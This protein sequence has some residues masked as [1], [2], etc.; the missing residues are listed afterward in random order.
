MLA[1]LA[2]GDDVAQEAVDDVFLEDAK[3]A[4]GEHVHLEGFEF[5]AEFVGDVAYDDVA[6]VREPGARADGGELGQLN[7]DLVA[8][9]LVFPA[10][11]V[12]QHGVDTGAG[13]LVSISA[14]LRFGHVSYSAARVRLSKSRKR[15][16]SVTTP[17]A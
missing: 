10:F 4:V 11:N 7:F 17:T 8:G 16:T 12:R 13:V 14:L 5:E 1:G 15:P 2:G 9:V 3:V 6:V